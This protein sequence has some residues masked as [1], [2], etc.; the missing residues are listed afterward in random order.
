MPTK[1]KGMTSIEIAILVGIVLAIAIAAGWY[2][3]TTFTAS[4]GAQVL[5]R[6]VS[7]VAFSNGTIKIEVENMGGAR[8]IF[9]RAEVFD[10]LYPLRNNAWYTAEPGRTVVV[11][12]DT[13]RWI[14]PG[15]IIQGKLITEDGYVV[16]FSARVIGS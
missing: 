7:T 3:Y 8:V 14:H 11:Y 6:V 10:T 12:I 16:P 4:V 5:L 2:L 1:V 15:V 13:N 9:V